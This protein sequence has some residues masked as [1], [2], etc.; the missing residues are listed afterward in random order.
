MNT[1]LTNYLTLFNALKPP[2]KAKLKMKHTFQEIS[3]VPL[4]TQF[5]NRL[6][7]WI[8]KKYIKKERYNDIDVIPVTLEHENSQMHQQSWCHSLIGLNF[9]KKFNDHTIKFTTMIT[10]WQKKPYSTMHARI[11][12][13]QKCTHPFIICSWCRTRDISHIQNGIAFEVQAKHIKHI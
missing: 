8:N 2:I 13:A 1:S 4:R 3:I 12:G 7:Y 6:E 10:I 5:I 9:Y 11:M